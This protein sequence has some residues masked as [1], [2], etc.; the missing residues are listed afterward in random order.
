MKLVRALHERVMR[1]GLVLADQ[2]LVSGASFVTTMLLVR[3]LG[4]DGFGR[5]SLAWMAVVFAQAL[6]LACVGTPMATLGPK[7]RPEDAPA[8]HA[9]VLRLE[10]AFL[11]A[12]LAVGLGAGLPI[13]RAFG[14]ELDGRELGALAA[15]ALARL[16]HDFV[17]QRAFV[18]EERGLALR[19]DAAATCVQLGLVATLAF[20]GRLDPVGA[21]AC[22]AAGSAAGVVAG[23]RH[24]GPWSVRPGALRRAFARH[25]GMAR[26]LVALAVL[27]WFTSNAFGL[28]AG[29]V[30]GPAALGAVRAGQTVLGVLHVGLLAIE[31]VVPVRAAALS[32]RATAGAAAAYLAR[33]AWIGGACTVSLSALVAL[34]A[35]QIAGVVYGA[36]APETVLAVRVFA[37]HYVAVFLITVATIRLRT[38][39][40]TR[41]MFVAQALGALFALAAARASVEAFGL[42]GALAGMVLQQ[43][44]VLLVLVLAVRLG[45]GDQAAVRTAAGAP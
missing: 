30:L 15:F 17:R 4:L 42:G 39:E 43:V 36:A 19:I 16:A 13:A 7:E 3:A 34:A 2:A 26:W 22:L 5:F 8:Y 32:A 27:Q 14:V 31:N 40:R 21:L 20:A 38:Q 1:H 9:D 24:L 6:Q 41:P 18:R 37:V 45:R 29:A 12:V 11:G 35:P 44:L 25:E 28:A 33:V 23:A 10:L